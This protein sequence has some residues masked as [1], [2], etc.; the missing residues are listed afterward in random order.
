MSARMFPLSLLA[1][2]P[3]L[4]AC[5]SSSFRIVPPAPISPPTTSVV[6]QRPRAEVWRTL[7]PQIGQT[8]F[9]IN[10]LDQSSGLINV[11]YSGDPMR[12]VDCGRV[13][14]YVKNLAGPRSYAFPVAQP[15]YEFEWYSGSLF[16]VRRTS[17][18]EGRANIILEQTADS[19]TR[20]SVNVRYV[21]SLNSQIQARVGGQS[22][23]EAVT[24]SFTSR[25]AGRS[26]SGNTTCYPTGALEQKLLMLVGR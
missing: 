1:I 15:Q 26:A 21:L 11:S 24:V 6:V 17:T 2:P 8:F 7:V 25:E 3:L 4:G 23:Q 20:V 18:L 16:I 12:F 9:V 5:I 14:S 13:E 22:R 10:N 19:T